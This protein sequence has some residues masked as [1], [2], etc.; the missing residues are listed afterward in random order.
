MRPPGGARATDSRTRTGRRSV[1]AEAAPARTVGRSASWGGP[2]GLGRTD[3]IGGIDAEPRIIRACLSTQPRD[4]PSSHLSVCVCVT[5]QR[6][7]A[8]R[9]LAAC[10]VRAQ[11]GEASSGSQSPGPGPPPRPVAPDPG[12]RVQVTGTPGRACQGVR[13]GL[14]AQCL[15]AASAMAPG[16]ATSSGHATVTSDSRPPVLHARLSH[17]VGGIGVGWA[18]ERVGRSVRVPERPSSHATS[19]PAAPGLATSAPG[20]A[21][22]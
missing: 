2:G 5:E 8:R 18:P 17:R 10:A 16:H 20:L 11:R 4:G 1:Q 22:D 21:G 14:V 9:P 13:G 12:A 15:R 7:S 3:R 6:H 19:A